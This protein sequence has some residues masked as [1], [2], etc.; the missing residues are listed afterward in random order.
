M[1]VDEGVGWRLVVDPSRQPFSVLI[2]GSAWSVEFTEPEAL[3]LAEGIAVLLEQH[4]RIADQLMDDEDLELDWEREDLWIGL[5]VHQGLWA[6]RF[7]LESTTGRRGVE[8]GWDA[9]ASPA[10]ALALE[11]LP[12]RLSVGRDC[13]PADKGL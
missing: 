8:A 7:V 5:T 4:R 10:L 1:Q 6:L 11:A 13:R 2:G 12:G 9:A 3:T